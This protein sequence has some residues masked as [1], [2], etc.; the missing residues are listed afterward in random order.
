MALENFTTADI[1]F[2]ENNK[3]AI[4]S[5]T[6]IDVTSLN[7]TD[8]TYIGWDKGVDFFS[9]DFTHKVDGIY[10]DATG[11]NGIFAAWALG[12]ILGDYIANSAG[13]S[14]TILSSENIGSL[15]HI[16]IIEFDNGTQ[17]TTTFE[18]S[19]S[20]V[21]YYFKVVRDENV[22][23]YGTIY[24]YIYSDAARTNLLSTLSN[25]LHSSK[26]D[27]RYLYAMQG[28]DNAQHIGTV[29]GRV[30]NLDIGTPDPVSADTETE[31]V[32]FRRGTGRQRIT[33][34]NQNLMA[35]IDRFMGKVGG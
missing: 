7:R 3:T 30:E 25:A 15:H 9:G 26:K 16:Y 29:T 14:L 13:D 5:A 34:Q 35:F 6:V 32:V 10:T 4:T 19:L 23:T 22:G 8:T 21:T 11:S 33:R 31:G 17:Y 28:Y 27:Y 20:P 2:D 12:N 24:L 1:D 18:G